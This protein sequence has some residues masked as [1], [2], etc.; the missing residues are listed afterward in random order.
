M[1]KMLLLVS[2][3]CCTTLFSQVT[4][5]TLDLSASTDTSITITNAPA[6]NGLTCGVSGNGNVNCIVFNVTLNP[7][8]DQISFDI[9]GAQGLGSAA[10]QVNCGTATSLATPICLNGITTATISFCK[11]GNNAY[12]YK[13]TASTLVKGS[14]DLTLRQNCS[15]TMSVTGL[16]AA[17]VTWTS[18]Y[19]G[20][21]GQYNSYLS[22]TSGVSSTTVTP[23]IGSPAYIDYRVS[24]STSSCGNAKAD[25]IRVYTTPALSVPITPA[26]PAICSNTPVALTA[27]PSGGNPPYTYSWSPGGETIATKNVTVAGTYTVTVSD[28]T[29]GCTPVSQ[30]VTVAALPTPAAPTVAGTSICAGSTATLTPSAPG[31]TYEWY[32]VASGGAPVFTGNSFTTPVL[33]STIT[34]YVQTTV[35]GCVSSRTAVTVTVN[36]IPA[37]PTVSSPTICSGNTAALSATAPGGSY[38]WYDAASGGTLLQTGAGYTTPLLN[39]TTSYYVQTTVLGCTSSRTAVTITVTPTPSAPVAGNAAICSGSGTTLTATS[40]GGTY[41]W[42]NVNTGGTS[43]QTGASYTTSTLNSSATYYV[44]TTVSGCTSSRTTVT[45]TVNAIPSI[46]SVSVPAIC[47]GNSATATVNSPVN[48]VTYQ[49]YDAPAAGNLLAT[50]TSYTTP[51]LNNASNYYVQSNVS[52][53]NSTRAT[54]A[55]TVNAAPAAPTVSPV[56]ICAGNTAILTAT[57][58]GGNYQ[59]YDA[60]SGGNLLASSSSYTTVVLNTT[61]QYYVQTTVAGCTG[62]RSAATVTVNPSPAAP[63]VLSPSICAGSNTS[64]TA[65][66]PGGTYQWYDAATGGNLLL[67]GTSFI[68]PVLNSSTTYYVQ[69]TVAG[70]LGSR[71]AVTVA[72][73]AAPAAP[74]VAGTAICAGTGTSLVATAPG[75]TYQWYDAATGGN[76]LNTGSV[77]TIPSLNTSSVYYVQTTVGSCSGARAGVTVT[78]NPI[79]SPPASSGGSVCA[80]NPL[81]LNA[82]GSGGTY[83]W[84]DSNISGNLLSGNSSFTSPVLNNT[85]VY[86]VQATVAGCTSARTAVTA[87]VIPILQPAFNYSSG[88]FCVTGSNPTPVI[89]RGAGGVFSASPAGL[90]FVNTATGEINLT[91]SALGTYTIQYVTGGQCTY[92]SSAKVTITN[93]PNAAFVYS[94]PYCPQQLSA[95]PDFSS[96]ASAGLFSAG[97]SGLVFMSTSTGEIDLQK[98]TPG[99]YAVTNNIVAAGGC[100]AATASNT[101]TILDKPVAVAGA[102]QTICAGIQVSLNGMVSG[103]ASSGTWSGG[104]GS[105]TDASQ[106]ITQYK[107]GIGES[108]V[109]LY[110]TSNDPSGPCTAAIDSLT[111]FI[112][113]LPAAPTVHNNAV[114]EGN[115]G[116][117]VA[118]APG[119]IYDWYTVP[120]GGA[121]VATGNTFTSPALTASSTYYV[122]S[123]IN[124][125]SGP[126]SS[127]TITVSAKPLLVSP[128]T[129]EVC[130]SNAFTYLAISNQ[131]GT[132]FTWSRSSVTGITNPATSGQTDSSITEVLINTTT[133]TVPVTYSIVPVNKGCT[134]DPFFYTASVK[135]TPTVPLISNNTPV[136]AGAPLNLSTASVTGASYQWNGPN[137]FSSAQQNPVLSNITTAGAGIYQ[138]L[139]TVNG[140]TSS[141]SSK[142]IA[143]VIAAPV[144]SSNSPVCEQGTLRLAAGGLTGAIYQWRGP[145]GFSNASQNP[146]LSSISASQAGVYYVTAS[147]A[148]CTGLTDSVKVTVNIPPGTPIVTSNSPVC[149]KDSITLK[150]V[151]ISGNETFQWSGPNGFQSVSPSPL[152]T[153]ADKPNEGIYNLTVSSPGCPITSASSVSVLVNQRPQITSVSN[154]GPLCEGDTLRLN[155]NS[156]PGAAYSWS[157]ASG[158]QSFVKNPVLTNITKANEGTYLVVASLSGCMS[159]TALT[160]INISTPAV[161]GTSGNSIVCANNASLKLSGTITGEDTHTG[162]WSSS[163]K[164]SFLP[165]ANQLSPVYVPD[166]ADTA[167]HKVVLTLTTTQNRVCPVSS[168]SMEL[169]ITPAPVVNAGPDKTVCSNDSLMY[170]LGDV[171]NASGGVWTS[172]GTGFF[173]QSGS[174]LAKVYTPSRTDIQKG[175]VRFYLLS[176]G[177]GNCL[178]VSDTVQYA[179]QPVPYVDAGNDLIIF[180][181]ETTQLSP[182]VKGTGLQ[183]L[184]TPSLNL[185]NDIIQNPILIGKN[186]QLYTLRVTGTGSCTV[187]DA[188]FVKVLK[189]ITIPNIF[190]PNGDGIHDTWEIPELNNYAGSFVEIFT[191]SGMK[192]FSSAGYA[193]PWDGTYNG[194]PVPVATYYY[195]IKPNFRNLVFSGSVTVIR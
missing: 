25:T 30:A 145:S 22:N 92:S 151:N 46:P 39:T 134:G 162:R 51:L 47:A 54:V 114:C 124:N 100:A 174:S 27:S 40:P 128:A 53:C 44:Q 31:G 116:M 82:N 190:S 58:P 83:Q 171:I 163:G 45:V 34:Y 14:G 131:P 90:V 142:N 13:I 189:P 105:F 156:F 63:T 165:D 5:V 2:L 1:K 20:T 24:G 7:R 87:T 164:G 78:V 119:G 99:N 193:K 170:L 129:G 184:W 158:Y 102:N 67:T 117:L 192:I 186:S 185:S 23:G 85:T 19:P 29:S 76:L 101:V 68:T 69:T 49:W 127:T 103:T 8:S 12:T 132:I 177:N 167:T 75:G 140:C 137:G 157:S 18:I 84:Y 66:A 43:L 91:A 123:T 37:A 130:S 147:V 143:P 62:L 11:N 96:G 108:V 57:A 150:T 64:L 4:T 95:L 6:R 81:T 178:A 38:N 86:Y 173:Q 122:Q 48:G 56:F 179:I 195:I 175:A 126:R 32:T 191:R 33:N 107:P 133:G 104:S 148:G 79:P 110:L 42:Y 109:K 118:T 155:A 73:Q 3:F 77:Y 160:R 60:A 180:E 98:S 52:G 135:P 120:S 21:A 161:A 65:T 89:L 94:G 121:S 17:S 136:C 55:V 144:A 88:T 113:P 176:S 172:S 154:N 188:V 182:V 93:S 194:K 181:N 111:L 50:G 71:A 146:L 28:N 59:W 61:A 183:F 74:T 149:S 115:T 166:A 36:P 10:Y 138:L 106:L 141:P 168:A 187:E 9:I 35:S 169:S 125:C 41:N 72:V 159:D 139:I 112:N 152:I 97:S 70:C 15:G 16:Q 153:K 26:N 80:G